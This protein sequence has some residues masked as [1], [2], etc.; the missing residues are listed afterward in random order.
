MSS[1]PK[2]VKRREPHKMLTQHPKR[3]IWRRN[4]AGLTQERLA[5][6]AGY[7]KQHISG[8]E[9]GAFGASAECM[10]ALARALDC[11]ITDL[12]PDEPNGSAA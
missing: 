2:P 7:T 8:L 11:K 9:K 5:E 6:M 4:A 1:Q 10:A 3:L 12:M